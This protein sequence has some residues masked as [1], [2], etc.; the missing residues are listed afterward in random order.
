MFSNTGSI[1]YERSCS[2]YAYL[3]VG[4][5][6]TAS[7]QAIIKLA[8]YRSLILHLCKVAANRGVKKSIRALFF[9]LTESGITCSCSLHSNFLLSNS[10]FKVEFSESRDIYSTNIFK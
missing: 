5:N 8:E 3:L 1:Y 4:S 2:R 10:D 9:A 7:K 6:E